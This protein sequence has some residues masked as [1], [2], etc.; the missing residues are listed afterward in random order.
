MSFLE[1]S[2]SG[3]ESPDYF[4]NREQIDVLGLSGLAGSGKDYMAKVAASRGDFI[5]LAL[6]NAFK[7]PEV[8]LNGLPIEQVYGDEDKTDDVRRQLQV[9]GKEMGRDIHGK[10]IWCRCAEVTMFYHHQ[11]G[12]DKFVVHDV[13]FPNEAEWVRSFNGKIYGLSG[14]GG[15]SG[16]HA[17]HASE[18]EVRNVSVD[19]MIDNSPENEQQAVYDFLKYLTEDFPNV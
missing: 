11:L 9:R 4:E 19:R 2:S 14:R 7:M 6:A 17:Q 8:V 12:A 5:P 16:E 3:E 1:P 18:T 15:E 10:W 13:R